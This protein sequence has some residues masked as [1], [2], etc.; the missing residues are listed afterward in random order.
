MSTN[1]IRALIPTASSAD[2]G[3][4]ATAWSAGSSA[5]LKR[6]HV[7]APPT[8]ATRLTAPIVP[9]KAGTS[10]GSRLR[11]VSPKV[12]GGG[13]SFGCPGAAIGGSSCSAAERA[14][15]ASLGR[16]SAT[17]GDLLD[18]PHRLVDRCE[19]ADGSGDATGFSSI[20][21]VLQDRGDRSGELIDRRGSRQVEDL[22]LAGVVGD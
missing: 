9:M 10:C 20:G 15:P 22:P 12:G 18:E 5:A 21:R 13:L 6:F 11:I 4:A 2:C 1:T 8:T 17:A 7:T 14:R 19:G 16:R 3:S